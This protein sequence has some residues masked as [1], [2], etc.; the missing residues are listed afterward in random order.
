[1]GHRLMA[2]EWLWDL[3]KLAFFVVGAY[4]V[5]Q[6]YAWHRQPDWSRILTRR[7]LALLGALALAM[8]AIKLIEDVVG[9]ESGP[10]DNA[11]LWFVREQVPAAL[12]GFF[13]VV[14]LSGSAAFLLPAS[15]I[16]VLALLL[17]TRRFEALLLSA[18]MVT[19]PLL[20]Y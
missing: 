2:L 3:A 14:T 5:L 19:A 7:R 15:V 10:V 6:A 9:K 12:S 13:S 17:A 1:M 20:V 11:I 8:S 16:A 18:S 4:W